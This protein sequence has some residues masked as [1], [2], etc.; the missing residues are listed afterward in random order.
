MIDKFKN[1]HDEE[2]KKFIKETCQKF[3]L[4]IKDCIKRFIKYLIQ[5][6]EYG[7]KR[8]WLD[9]FEKIIHNIKGEDEFFINYSV[10]RLY[11]LYKTL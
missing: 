11:E 10:F 8:S 7:R 3:N 1:S 6:T 2:I 5:N 9:V 4:D